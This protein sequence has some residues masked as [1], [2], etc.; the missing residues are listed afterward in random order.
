MFPGCPEC[1]PASLT[2]SEVR[3]NQTCSNLCSIHAQWLIHLSWTSGTSLLSQHNPSLLFHTG[4]WCRG[5]PE[6]EKCC[7]WK[8]CGIYWLHPSEHSCV[9]CSPC[10]A[11][12]W[13]ESLN[14]LHSRFIL[15]QNCEFLRKVRVVPL[16][17]SSIYLPHGQSGATHPVC[18]PP[19]AQ[20]SVQLKSCKPSPQLKKT[21]TPGIPLP[22][23]YTSNL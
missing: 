13:A 6:L 15:C 1:V 4:V 22:C 23:I 10:E 9:P 2:D 3:E 16:N 18:D 20:S 14:W 19:A 8:V 11:G 17:A 5:I 21:Q 7:W 12:W